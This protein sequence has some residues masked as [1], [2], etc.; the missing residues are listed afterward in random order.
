MEE[1]CQQNI[2]EEKGNTE[3]VYFIKFVY[4][5]EKFLPFKRKKSCYYDYA[6]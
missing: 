3:K 5:F 4:F 2:R 1:S 6:E